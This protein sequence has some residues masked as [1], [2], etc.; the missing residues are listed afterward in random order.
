MRRVRDALTCSNDETKLAKKKKFDDT[1]KSSM[2]LGILIFGICAVV[3]VVGIIFVNRQGGL[4]NTIDNIK[5]SMSTRRNSN[6][7]LSSS[8][9]YSHLDRSGGSAVIGTQNDEF[10]DGDQNRLENDFSRPEFV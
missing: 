9:G 4:Q 8:L 3:F 7:P 5:S 6:L 2:S 1:E 10:N